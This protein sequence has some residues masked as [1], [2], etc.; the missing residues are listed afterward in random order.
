VKIAYG[1]DLLGIMHR[2]QL[3]EFTIRSEVCPPMEVIRQA[4]IYAADL[5]GMKEQIGQVAEGFLADLIVVDGDPV[6]DISIMTQPDRYLKMV[7]KGG[8]ILRRAE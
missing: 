5:F 4:T 8:K 6:E 3:N 2:H 1:T 7:M